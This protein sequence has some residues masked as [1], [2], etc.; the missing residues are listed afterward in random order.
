MTGSD[1]RGEDTETTINYHDTEEV[2]AQAC[3]QIEYE[4]RPYIL[5]TKSEKAADKPFSMALIMGNG[6]NS[7]LDARELLILCLDQVDLAML[8]FGDD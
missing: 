6:I 5:I 8:E 7:L 4:E 2:N 3:Q 1:D